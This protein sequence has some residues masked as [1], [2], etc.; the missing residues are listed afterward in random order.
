MVS[1]DDSDR[2]TEEEFPGAAELQS[3]LFKDTLKDVL[4]D[5]LLL[6]GEEAS[7]DEVMRLMRERRQACV[8]VTRSGVLA[9]IFTE[10]DVLMKIV[11]TRIDLERTPV[12]HYM[13]HNPVTL[14]AD[15]IVAY[16]LN[17]MVVEGFRHVPIV[18]SRRYPVG[19]VSM[20]DI[21]G[22]LAS[23]FPK[24]LLNLPPEPMVFRHREGA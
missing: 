1:P 7:L 17:K 6:V 18:D 23:Y 13:T 16:A 24:D 20:R 14:T 8:L 15:A 10:R 21:I 9:G 19:V 3:V 11:G 4:S 22:Y 5:R 12:K 2:V